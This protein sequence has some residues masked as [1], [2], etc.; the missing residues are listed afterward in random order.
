LDSGGGLSVGRAERSAQTKSTHPNPTCTGPTPLTMHGPRGHI[1]SPCAQQNGGKRGT[2]RGGARHVVCG[3]TTPK[4]RENGWFSPTPPTARGCSQPDQPQQ[5]HAC[6]SPPPKPPLDAVTQRL[7]PLVPG[8]GVAQVARP[9]QQG[10]VGARFVRRTG[11]RVSTRGGTHK[12]HSPTQD[13]HQ[14]AGGGG[15]TGTGTRS[16]SLDTLCG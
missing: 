14:Q 9:V 6:P 12:A 4:M 7:T 11:G 16:A 5:K 10:G 15:G 1:L 3:C 13:R 2:G 8:E